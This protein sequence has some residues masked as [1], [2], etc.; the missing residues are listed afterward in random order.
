M[1]EENYLLEQQ[2]EIKKKR[3]ITYLEVNFYLY[4]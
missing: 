2:I 3:I 4:F 1:K